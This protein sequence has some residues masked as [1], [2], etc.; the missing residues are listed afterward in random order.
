M[1][2]RFV[3]FSWNRGKGGL[4][5]VS[6]KERVELLQLYWYRLITD[7]TEVRTGVMNTFSLRYD[8]YVG[9]TSSVFYAVDAGGSPPQP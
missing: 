2:L 6:D 9:R 5:K 3:Y 8:Y 7:S 1:H 4:N